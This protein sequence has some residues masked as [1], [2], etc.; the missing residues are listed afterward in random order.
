[1]PNVKKNIRTATLSFYKANR[2][3]L[4]NVVDVE[5]PEAKKRCPKTQDI[6][7]LDN[8]FNSLRDK[9]ML[10]F[11]ASAP[12]RVETLT[13]LR[14]NDLKPTHDKDVPYSL[15]IESERLKGKGK[16]KYKGLKQIGFLHSLAV[17]KLEAYKKELERKGYVPIENSPIFIPYRQETEI[18]KMSTFSVERNFD[19]ASL[20]A[21]HDLEKK[22]FSPQD[23]RDYVQSALESAG[24]HANMISPLMAH[25]VKGVDFHYSEHG[26]SELLQKFKT[27]LPYLLPQSVEKLKAES[28]KDQ[29]RM[30]ELE[31]QVAEM[32]EQILRKLETLS[33]ELEKALKKLYS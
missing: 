12:F 3:N 2:R 6:V 30:T 29:K 26:I 7:D 11:I 20:R 23:F 8:A 9:A 17:Q 16:G 19:E 25:K 4:V 10:W 33:P 32:P 22:R 21:W 15:L 27:A 18:K 31:K 13:L 24:I 5:T 28:D 14:W 1:M